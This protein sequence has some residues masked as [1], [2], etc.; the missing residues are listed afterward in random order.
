[1]EYDSEISSK[2]YQNNRYRDQFETKSLLLDV[3]ITINATSFMVYLPEELT[4]NI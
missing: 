1:M 3:T 2:F 4:I